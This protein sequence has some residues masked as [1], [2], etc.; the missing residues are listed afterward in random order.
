MRR[1]AETATTRSLRATGLALL[2]AA[3]VP[4]GL[5]LRGIQRDMTTDAEAKVGAIT[6]QL[7]CRFWVNPA[8]PETIYSS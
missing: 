8:T 4:H 6:L 1:C 3:S 2:F 5:E 7:R